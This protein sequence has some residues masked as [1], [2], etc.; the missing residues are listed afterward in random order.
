M[1]HDTSTSRQ[2]AALHT[3]GQAMLEECDTVQTPNQSG[4]VAVS[5]AASGV[6]ARSSSRFLFWLGSL[7]IRFLHEIQEIGTATWSRAVGLINYGKAL[8]VRRSLQRAVFDAQLAL[9]EQMYAAGIDDGELGA[10]LAA[11]DEKIRQAKVTSIPTRT[12][13]AQRRKL[14]L[15]LAA[16]ALVEEAP[17]PRGRC[18]IR[19]GEESPGS[20]CHAQHIHER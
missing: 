16:A 8:W 17:P 7:G 12:L 18:R 9:G 4:P 20:T 13:T 3:V 5:S 19:K 11:L 15:Q 14:V 6:P 1:P 10:Q 2:A